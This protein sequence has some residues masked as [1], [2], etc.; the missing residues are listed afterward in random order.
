MSCIFKFFERCCIRK[1]KIKETNTINEIYYINSLL[2]QTEKCIELCNNFKNYIEDGEHPYSL[3]EESYNLITETQ[4]LVNIIHKLGDTVN[5]IEIEKSIITIFTISQIINY[6]LIFI[7]KRIKE[8]ATCQKTNII[9]NV[10]EGKKKE[11]SK[12]ISICQLY[13][14]DAIN[15]SKLISNLSE[16]NT[17]NIYDIINL[18]YELLMI[19]QIA[20]A[21]SDFLYQK[22]IS[23]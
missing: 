19:I 2:L 17:K 20:I 3:I 4:N 12:I 1:E 23:I 6:V 8:H 9:E 11:I 22:L 7:A 14:D 15:H 16:I 18:T 5:F 10:A 21:N 13:I